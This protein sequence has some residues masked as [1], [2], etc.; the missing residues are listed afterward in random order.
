[1]GIGEVV[2]GRKVTSDGFKRSFEPIRD[3]Y[4]PIHFISFFDISRSNFISLG[5][6]ITLLS[7][8]HHKEYDF[9]LPFA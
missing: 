5:L 1:M 4:T 2:L 8:W 9:L 3:N 6:I 7:A